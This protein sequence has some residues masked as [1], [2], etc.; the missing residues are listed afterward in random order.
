MKLAREPVPRGP[1]R[2]PG[3]KE[4]VHRTVADDGAGA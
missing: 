1:S 2:L 4:A 3:R